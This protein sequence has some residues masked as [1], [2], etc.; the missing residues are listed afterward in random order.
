LDLIFVEV[1]DRSRGSA[2]RLTGE[3][4]LQ[5]AVDAAIEEQRKGF[6]VRKKHLS[7]A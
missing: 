6:R 2:D 4:G 5:G 7:E 3:C 1:T